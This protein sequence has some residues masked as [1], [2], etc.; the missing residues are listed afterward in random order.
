ML[1]YVVLHG[2]LTRAAQSQVLASEAVL[3]RLD[4][5]TRTAEGA[6]DTVPVVWFDPPGWATVLEPDAEVVVV[7][8]VRR[9]FFSIGGATQSR[10]EVVA[11]RVVR[12]GSRRRTSRALVEAA[13]S[14]EAA[15]AAIERG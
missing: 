11:D 8:R 13:V 14:L 12:A 10:T 1:N 3:V 9:R 7:G 4:L 15:A 6:A 2:T 5:R